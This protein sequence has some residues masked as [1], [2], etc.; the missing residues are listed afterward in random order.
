MTTR[1]RT[2]PRRPKHVPAKSGVKILPG[3]DEE[4]PAPPFLPFSTH[5]PV[6]PAEQSDTSSSN[7]LPSNPTGQSSLESEKGRLRATRTIHSSSLS[8]QSQGHHRRGSPPTRPSQF[9]PQRRRLAKEAGSDGTPSM[10][11]S[12]SDLDEANVTQ[13][14]MEEV[15]AGEMQTGV[16]SKMSTIS[17]ALRSRYNF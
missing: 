8:N 14:A 9:S 15:L 12:F 7:D 2:F 4:E 3:T 11:S 13:S 17:Q 1:S 16:V 5:G 10:G 6:I